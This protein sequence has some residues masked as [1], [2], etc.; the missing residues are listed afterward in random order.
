MVFNMFK[1]AMFPNVHSIRIYELVS[2]TPSIHDLTQ[3]L[4]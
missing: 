2:Y 3:S 1:W 4:L